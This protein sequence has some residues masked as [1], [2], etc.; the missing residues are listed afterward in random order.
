MLAP[1][2][3]NTLQERVEYPTV[4]AD[5]IQLHDLIVRNLGI[6]SVVLV[7]GVDGDR[8]P[9]AFEGLCVGEERRPVSEEHTWE[10]SREQMFESVTRLP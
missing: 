8:L 7:P 1:R 10:Q 5:G 3:R 2:F 4:E 9:P 6:L